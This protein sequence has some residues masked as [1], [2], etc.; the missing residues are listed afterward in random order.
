M[1]LCDREA[2]PSGRVRGGALISGPKWKRTAAVCT[3]CTFRND[4]AAGVVPAFTLLQKKSQVHFARASNATLKN[5]QD[6]PVVIQ[7]R[8]K[9]RGLMHMVFSVTICACGFS[10]GVVCLDKE[11]S[12]VYSV[13]VSQ[14]KCKPC[15]GH[16]FCF[17][18]Q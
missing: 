15:V 13:P 6:Q 5:H 8:Y 3:H 14:L 2:G 1:Q 4:R 12:Y 17:S 16:V 7:V 9:I 11:S 10:I 18:S